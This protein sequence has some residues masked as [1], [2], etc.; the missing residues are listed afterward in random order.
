[1]Y[2]WLDGE[3]VSRERIDDLPRFA[4]TLAGFLARWA[5]PTRPAGRRPGEHNFYRGGPLAAYEEET[6]CRRWRRS[7]TRCPATAVDRVWEDAMATS[8]DGEPMW[9]HGD[10]AVGNL[11]VRDGRLGAVIDFGSSASAIPPAT[12]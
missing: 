10:V 4:T 12:S 5:A 7:A 9:F 3:L 1:M 2:R 8:W 6:R 11:L